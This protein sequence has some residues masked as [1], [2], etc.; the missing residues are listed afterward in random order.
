MFSHWFNP[1]HWFRLRD[2]S[3]SAARS[4]II[5]LTKLDGHWR[6][7]RRDQ[8]VLDAT[9]VWVNKAKR[10]HGIGMGRIPLFQNFI[11]IDGARSCSGKLYVQGLN[12]Q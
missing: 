3:I 7:D 6:Y 2:E 5:A 8:R 12:L 10:F 9:R 1:A 4:N 11:C